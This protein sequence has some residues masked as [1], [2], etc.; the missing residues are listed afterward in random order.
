MKV[1]LDGSESDISALLE[2]DEVVLVE[3]VDGEYR[4]ERLEAEVS[5]GAKK[6]PL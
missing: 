6:E 5:T 1:Y 2:V 4:I 3:V